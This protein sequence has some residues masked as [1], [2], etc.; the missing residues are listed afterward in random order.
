M[1]L[2]RAK[3]SLGQHFLTDLSISNRICDSYNST[4]SNKINTLEIGPGMGVLTQFLLKRDDIN[5]KMVEV[6][7]ESVNF[8]HS[9]FD[10]TKDQLIEADFL[11]LDLFN[12]FDHTS[13]G[14]IGNF[15]YNIS[16]QIFFHILEQKDVVTE[17]VCMLQR[18][19]AKRLSSGPGNKDYGILSV[20]L[21]AYYDVEYLFTVDENVFNP[22]PKVKSG[23]IRLKR[24][25]VKQLN[26]DE[27]LFRLVVKSTFNQRRKTIWNSIRSINFDYEK[28]K[29]HRFMKMRPEQLSVSEFVELTNLV[30]EYSK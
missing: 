15:P 11:K 20:F 14:V 21:Q 25:S 12:I 9:H 1:N 19:V 4:K 3:K 6:D 23:V 27:K 22:P 5:L 7:S 24:N 16:S 28:T 30:S 17:I 18:E 13:F 26:C 8:L 10:I 2:V 29:D